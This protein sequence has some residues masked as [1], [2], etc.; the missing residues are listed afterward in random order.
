MAM[1]RTS[2]RTVLFYL[3]TPESKFLFNH[4]SVILYA[5]VK[6]N[7]TPKKSEEEE[8]EADDEEKE[9]SEMESKVLDES[10]VAPGRCGRF[11]KPVAEMP[12]TQRR[13]V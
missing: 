4:F 8:E 6:P 9:G 7:Q 13:I 11:C 12:L 1:E 10:S 3:S 5:M 2:Q